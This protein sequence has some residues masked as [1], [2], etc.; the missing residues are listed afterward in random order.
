[1]DKNGSK[2]SPILLMPGGWWIY[3]VLWKTNICP[4]R[5]PLW[6]AFYSWGSSRSLVSCPTIEGK[7]RD[8]MRETW[9]RSNGHAD[10]QTIKQL[11]KHATCV[12]AAKW[13]S[14]NKN[15]RLGDP[16]PDIS[17]IGQ[18]TECEC[19]RFKQT[20]GSWK[21]VKSICFRKSLRRW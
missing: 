1:M 21:P 3:M 18:R 2:T 20:K 17:D 4:Q 16:F 12:C 13:D 11:V 10:N 19:Q 7:G 15:H 9:F 5:A 14:T 6:R 8:S